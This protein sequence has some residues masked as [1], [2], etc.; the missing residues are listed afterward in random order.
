MQAAPDQ[1]FNRTERPRLC[2]GGGRGDCSRMWNEEV[3]L[4]GRGGGGPNSGPLGE[5]EGEMKMNRLCWG[6][7]EEKAHGRSEGWEGNES[8]SICNGGRPANCQRTARN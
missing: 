2:V 4:L 5:G 1:L 3:L 6:H 8:K 7:K